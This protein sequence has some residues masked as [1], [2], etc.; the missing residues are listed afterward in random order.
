[1]CIFLVS[2]R[3]KKKT[4][5]TPRSVSFRGLIQ[6]FLRASPPLSYAESPTGSQALLHYHDKL[7]FFIFYKQYD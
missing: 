2:F 4:W 5:A 3:G 1:M 6:N 7:S